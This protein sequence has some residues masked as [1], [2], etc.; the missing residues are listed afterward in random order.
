[1]GDCGRQDSHRFRF[2]AKP[3]RDA[4]ALASPAGSSRS[5]RTPRTDRLGGRRRTA[6]NWDIAP[7]RM[8]MQGLR[9][10][11]LS[12]AALAPLWVLALSTDAKSVARNPIIGS[13]YLTRRGLPHRP[14]GLP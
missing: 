2:A 1:M 6:A 7:G 5:R 12:N 9:R 3:R 13:R 10:F 4:V 8:I 11:R 14:A